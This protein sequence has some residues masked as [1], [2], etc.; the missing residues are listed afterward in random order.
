MKKQKRK[1]REWLEENPIDNKCA[2][3][4]GSLPP[5]TKKSQAIAFNNREEGFKFLIATDAIGMGLNLS[6]KRIIFT[7]LSKHTTNGKIDISESDIKQIA[8]RA[9][10]YKEDGFV[11]AFTKNALKRVRKVIDSDPK[12]N[13][14]QNADYKDVVRNVEPEAENEKFQKME[15]TIDSYQNESTEEEEGESDTEN[16]MQFTD[17]EE[18]EAEESEY[19]FDKN[20]VTE[21]VIDENF[22][23]HQSNIKKA[24]IFPLYEQLENFSSSVFLK[25][26]KI[27]RFSEVLI[28]FSK[29]AKL[30]DLYFMRNIS[31]YAMIAK[32]LDNVANLGNLDSIVNTLKYRSVKRHLYNFL[33]VPLRLN[34][35]SRR[36]K[37]YV[38][39]GFFIQLINTKQVRLPGGDILDYGLL[40]E[41][42]EEDL[43]QIENIHNILE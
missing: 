22:T 24:C 21:S 30:G 11:T 34:A 10:R 26:G 36:R 3:I 14:S 5:E 9:G 2:L 19:T 28:K 1:L 27:L 25:E 42:T 43:E 7:N 38:L 39:K 4:Y 12:N 16:F 29:Q 40:E 13:N 8:G 32:E 23:A 20:N 17:V 15:L 18:D 33:Q 37:L 41:C 6:I 35:A 31:E